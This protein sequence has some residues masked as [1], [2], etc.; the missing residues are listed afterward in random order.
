MKIIDLSIPIEDGLPSDPPIQIPKIQYCNHKDTAE[1]MA[2][3]FKGCTV[4]DLP[5]GNGWG[6]EFLQVCTHSGTHVD[7]PYHYYPTMNGGEKAWTIDEVPLDWFVGD[8][9]V[10]D[11]HD[12]PDGY[13]I[14]AKDVEEYFEKIGYTL[15][16]GDI[17][18]L[19]TDADDRWGK[20]EYLVAGAGMSYEAT[21]W[22]L[23]RGVH[24][25]GTDGW[26]WDVPLP[27]EGA[28]FEKNHDASIIWEAHRVGRDKAYCHIEKLTNLDQLPVTGFKVSCFPVSI[29][30]ASAGWS[31]VVAFVD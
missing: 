19:R 12:K 14:T 22:L 23:N 17:V 16:E 11:F 9:V 26:S 29:K 15:K 5:D 6:I 4:A 31:R 20:P 21:M 7:A 28:E 10:M 25:V 1:Q 13:K 30:A 27:F 8:G 3:F 2:G 24:V 18:L